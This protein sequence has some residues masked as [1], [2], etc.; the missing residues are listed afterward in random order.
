MVAS[1]LLNFVFLFEIPRNLLVHTCCDNRARLNFAGTDFHLLLLKCFHAGNRMSVFH[2]RSVATEQSRIR[3]FSGLL[4]FWSPVRPQQTSS[5]EVQQ[6]THR[7]LVCCLVR[8]ASAGSRAS[9]RTR[10]NPLAPSEKLIRFPH[11]VFNT[12]RLNHS[13]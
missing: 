12:V 4:V 13:G 1:G 3:G 9:S 7:F 5:P 10:Q 2:T 11:S 6:S 8:R